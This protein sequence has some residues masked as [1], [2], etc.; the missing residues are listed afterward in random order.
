LYN[1]R[2]EAAQGAR[3][4]KEKKQRCFFFHWGKGLL[5]PSVIVRP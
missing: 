1:T 3:L 4:K 5:S 2:W